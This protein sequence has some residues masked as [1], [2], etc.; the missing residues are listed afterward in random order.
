MPRSRFEFAGVMAIETR[1]ALVTVRVPWPVTPDNVAL[2]VEEPVERLVAKP[3]PDIVT[4]VVLEEAQTTEAVM[5]LLD[6]SW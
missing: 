2:I 3:P 6:P 5:P 1:I 4:T